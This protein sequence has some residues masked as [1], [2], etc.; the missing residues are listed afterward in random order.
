[1]KRFVGF[2]LK[3]PIVNIAVDMLICIPLSAGVFLAFTRIMPLSPT[4]PWAVWVMPLVGCLAVALISAYKKPSLLLALIAL[5]SVSMTVNLDNF[6]FLC[7]RFFTWWIMMHMPQGYEF[8]DSACLAVYWLT[9]L[10]VVLIVWL[11]IRVVGRVK[12]MAFWCILLVLGFSLAGYRNHTLAVLLMAAGLIPLAA[13]RDP[14][15][16]AGTP[17]STISVL[18][19]LPVAAVC[20]A[21]GTLLIGADAMS[22]RYAPLGERVDEAYL[23]IRS[24]YQYRRTGAYGVTWTDRTS[25]FSKSLGGP[26]TP[27]NTRVLTVKTDEPFLLRGAVYDYYDGHGWTSTIAGTT[28]PLYPALP[29]A[30]PDLPQP[31]SDDTLAPFLKA[32]EA[33]VTLHR[34]EGA[35]VYT[36]GL[37]NGFAPEALKASV[38]ADSSVVLDAPITNGMTYTFSALL[39]ERD[40]LGF[41]EGVDERTPERWPYYDISSQHYDGERS[42]MD[43]EQEPDPALRQ[44]SLADYKRYTQLPH[45]E[46]TAEPLSEISIL[47]ENLV[48]TMA[49]Q[50][51]REALPEISALAKAVTFDVSTSYGRNKYQMALLLESWLKENFAYTLTPV[52]PPED[53]EF[54]SHFLETRE[55]YCVYYATAMAVMART[56]GIPSR[57]VTGYRLVEE[58]TGTYK[59]TTG[60]AHAWVELHFDGTGWVTFDPTSPAG[61]PDEPIAAPIALP[62]F[63]ASQLEADASDPSEAQEDA[64][65]AEETKIG[66]QTQAKGALLWP[67][68]AATVAGVI[69]ALALLILR[70]RSL[71]KKAKGEFLLD[72]ASALESAF[73]SIREDIFALGI[74][75]SKTETLLCFARR[76]SEKLLLDRGEM[77][78]VTV[79]LCALR[80]GGHSPLDADLRRAQ[81]L[82]TR[83]EQ[84][85]ARQTNA[86][87]FPRVAHIVWPWR[88]P[89]K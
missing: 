11:F 27:G 69:A 47:A 85:R 84:K 48:Y 31:D 18:W 37:L 34:P 46:S 16:S 3:T 33:E 70:K 1:M 30:E 36:A 77:M 5:L 14:R 25:A 35:L 52:M 22:M 76:A 26:N 6:V 54:V 78:G 64:L 39:L 51:R 71:L 88:L 4:F 82:K 75:Q 49:S 45:D 7:R 56:L 81:S 66:A 23:D 28:Q 8:G 53:Q 72:N 10:F 89:G 60:T 44:L 74:E 57:Y 62:T 21:L 80:Y 50:Y 40:A 41:D 58:G 61:I 68:L 79:A 13:R 73:Q 24:E 87:R 29:D 2:Q 9:A 65:S 20:V 38:R 83:L 55:G 63:D 12:W 67:L 59:A 17:M 86:R 19:A 15:R 43:A 42:P 32:V